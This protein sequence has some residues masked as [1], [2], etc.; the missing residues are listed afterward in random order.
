MSKASEFVKLVEQEGGYDFPDAGELILHIDNT[1][2]IY[3]HKVDAFKNLSKKKKAGTY[4]ASL[5]PKL[6]SYLADEAAKS[7]AKFWNE[8]NEVDPPL[9]W[10]KVFTKEVRVQAAQDLVADF[11]SA[12]ENKEYDFMK[13]GE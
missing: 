7:A 11:E 6:F 3:R 5:A 2:P 12:F 8:Y 10:N 4:D 13:E 1:E 9:P